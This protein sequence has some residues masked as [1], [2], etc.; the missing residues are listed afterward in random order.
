MS[1]SEPH[2]YDV[3]RLFTVRE[4][5]LQIVPII[6][7]AA[8]LRAFSGVAV[9]VRPKRRFVTRHRPL[10]HAFLVVFFGRPIP[11]VHFESGAALVEGDRVPEVPYVAV[12]FG[13][14]ETAREDAHRGYGVPADNDDEDVW[15]L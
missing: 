15:I 2:L 11:Q 1:T 9:A 12:G 8:A 7:L 3:S 5:P 10:L 13:E 6:T 4:A 14:R